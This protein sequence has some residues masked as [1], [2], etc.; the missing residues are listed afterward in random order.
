MNLFRIFISN[1]VGKTKVFSHF[2]CLKKEDGFKWEQENHRAFDDIK[3]YL[4]NP[5]LLPS[6]QNK[7]MRLYISAADSTIGS[8]LAQEDDDGFEKAICYLIRLLIDEKTRYD[9]I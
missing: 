3:K 7:S 8:M 6:I 5:Y 1:L 2:L 4:S 9:S